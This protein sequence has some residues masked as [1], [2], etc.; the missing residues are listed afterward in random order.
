[1]AIDLLLD[2]IYK[3]LTSEMQPDPDFATSE[4]WPTHSAWFAEELGHKTIDRRC[5]KSTQSK[6]GRG[7]RRCESLP[8]GGL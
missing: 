4:F 7:P 8:R 3:H 5:N 1:M 6:L 2:T